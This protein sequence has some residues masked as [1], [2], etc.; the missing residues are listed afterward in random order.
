MRKRGFK[1]PFVT[2]LVRSLRM[3]EPE[4]ITEVMVDLLGLVYWIRETWVYFLPR[5]SRRLRVKMRGRNPS[6]L[7]KGLRERR[8]RDRP[9]FKVISTKNT[10]Q[11]FRL[12]SLWKKEGDSNDHLNQHH[13][14]LRRFLLPVIEV[15]TLFISTVIETTVDVVEGLSSRHT[16][17]V[18]RLTSNSGG[19]CT[20]RSG[21]VLEYL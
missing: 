15:P 21:L 19:T 8:S 4:F 18:Y 10:L 5:R 16:T 7:S 2:L 17:Q 1:R 3:F 12:D 13:S 14:N 9:L 11:I 6:D 20:R